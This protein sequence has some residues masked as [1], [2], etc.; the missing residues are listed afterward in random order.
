MSTSWVVC[1]A[2]LHQCPPE[3]RAHLLNYLPISEKQ[4]VEQLPKTYQDPTKGIAPI[5][6]QL[7]RIHHSWFSPYLRTLSEREIKLFAA[8]LSESQTASLKKDLRFSAS[9]PSLKPRA[10]NYLQSILIQE[11]K[12]KELDILPL[13]C[14]PESSLN[15][16]LELKLVDLLTVV[17]F[18]GLHDLAAEMR[19]II[20][21]VKLKKISEALSPTEIKYVEILTQSREPVIFSRIGLTN[22]QGD[23]ESLR[24]IIQQR[25]INRLGK[26][27]YGQHK[28]FIW[29]LIHKV[30]VDRGLAIQKL[31]SPLENTL[32]TKLLIAQVLELLS[33]MRQPHE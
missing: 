9:L 16:L 28:S 15:P 6:V 18:L 27:L 5:K 11:V 13:E 20:E 29:H 24:T 33:F 30:D 14:L 23:K 17:T 2:F 25:G 12:G 32:G 21:T 22:W 7:E 4:I 3:K 10:K 31:C 26:A 8:A 19:H 1:S